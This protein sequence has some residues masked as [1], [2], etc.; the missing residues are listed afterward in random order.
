VKHLAEVTDRA[1]GSGFQIFHFSQV[2]HLSR[3][4]CLTDEEWSAARTAPSMLS[5]SPAFGSG[6]RRFQHGYRIRSDRGEQHGHHP[7]RV[8]GV[9]RHGAH[10]CSCLAFRTPSRDWGLLEAPRAGPRRGE[11]S[12]GRSCRVSA[13]GRC[14]CRTSSPV[15]PRDAW[16]RTRKGATTTWQYT[17]EL[18]ATTADVSGLSRPSGD[19][20]SSAAAATPRKC[21]A[22]SART[23][24]CGRTGSAS[25]PIRRVSAVCQ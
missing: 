5:P 4:G 1:L 25:G 22:A 14:K 19:T 16:A 20:A 8:Q 17:R 3:T 15:L 2:F 9:L 21:V 6:R 18:R 12:A 11:G 23:A 13:H 10:G 7:R 24:S